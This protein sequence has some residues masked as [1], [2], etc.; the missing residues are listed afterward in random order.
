MTT[1]HLFFLGSKKKPVSADKVE[2]RTRDRSQLN[3]QGSSVQKGLVNKKRDT[4]KY[5]TTIE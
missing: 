4:G 5:S 3:L 1:A 2:R